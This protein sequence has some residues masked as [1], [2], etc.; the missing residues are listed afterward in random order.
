MY[1]KYNVYK[2]SVKLEKNKLL[3]IKETFRNDYENRLKNKNIINEK[4]KAIVRVKY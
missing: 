2:D 1:E 4:E 3:I